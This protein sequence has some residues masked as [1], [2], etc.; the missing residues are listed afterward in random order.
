MGWYIRKGFNFGPF[1]INLSKGGVGVSFGFKG[2]RIGLNRLGP[3]LHVGWGGLYY[4]TY[5]TGRREKVE[6]DAA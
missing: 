2:F 3:Y 6:A 1:R 5:L 4:R